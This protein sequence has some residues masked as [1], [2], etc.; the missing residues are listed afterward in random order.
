MENL[1]DKKWKCKSVI[2]DGED[3]LINGLNIWEHKWELTGKKVVVK[4][5]KYKKLFNVDIFKIQF[6]QIQ[7]EFAAVEF[8]N[9]VWGIYQSE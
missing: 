7:A 3:F 2:I 5:P 1:E 6:N 4:D 8:S 9:C